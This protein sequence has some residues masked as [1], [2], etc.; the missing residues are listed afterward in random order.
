MKGL[1]VLSVVMLAVCSNPI[2]A[3][4]AVSRGVGTGTCAQFAANYQRDRQWWTSMCLGHKAIW[5]QP[6]SS[7]N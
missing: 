6:T 3:E 2:R 1:I 4:V 7:L 5:P